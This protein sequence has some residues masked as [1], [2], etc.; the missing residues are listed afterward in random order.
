M[1]QGDIVAMKGGDIDDRARRDLLH[2][3]LG[4]A[5]IPI[6]EG[7]FI[8]PMTEDDREGGMIFSHPSCDPKIGVQGQSVF[9]A[10]RDMQPGEALTHDWATTDDDAYEMP[11]HCGAANCRQLI[12]GHDGKRTDVQEKDQDYMSGYLQQKIRQAS[13]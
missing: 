6:A 5:A 13:A 1:T 4:P 9:V 10:M 8:G 2:P 12:T 11:C 3:P 7:F